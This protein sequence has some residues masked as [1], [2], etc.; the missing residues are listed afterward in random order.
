MG[1]ALFRPLYRDFEY[2]EKLAVNN[3]CGGDQRYNLQGRF[4]KPELWK[5]A[6][7]G[8]SVQNICFIEEVNLDGPKENTRVTWKLKGQWNKDPGALV[9]VTIQKFDPEKKKSKDLATLAKKISPKA[10]AVTVDL[11]P[12]SGK[13]LRIIIRKVG[14]P[15]TG[16]HSAVFDLE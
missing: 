1:S 16:G 5:L 9:S 15:E 2:D 10:G 11:S 4:D 6:G 3:D 8:I 13:N 7:H 14:D 12:Y